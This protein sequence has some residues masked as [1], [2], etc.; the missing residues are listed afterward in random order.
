MHSNKPIPL[1]PLPPDRQSLAVSCIPLACREA[2][3]WFSLLGEE[4]AISTAY[5]FL[6]R[7]AAKYD[8]ARGFKF[9]TM[10]TVYVRHGL[11]REL[12][13]RR[14]KGRRDSYLVVSDEGNNE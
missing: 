10:A 7:A 4:D 1:S 3:R 11:V 14:S 6:C 12:D 9:S 5:L 13:I 2:K 8:P